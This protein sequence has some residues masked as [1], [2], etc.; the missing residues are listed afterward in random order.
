MLLTLS[1]PA[2]LEF[3]FKSPHEFSPPFSSSPK[4]F[5]PRLNG[6]SVLSLPAS[7]SIKMSTPHRG[8]P[9]PAAMTLPDPGGRGPPPIPT[10]L[11]QLPA[12][13]T[14]WQGAEDG[15]RNWLAAKA[16]E[17][18]RKQE[19]EK[20]RQE[21]LKMKQEDL[22][23]QQ[24]SYRL[25]QR[26]I[27]QAMLRESMQG[28]VPPHLVPMIFAGIG[29]ANL[30]NVSLEW[31][32]QYAAQLQAAQQQQQQQQQQ[33]ALNQAQSPEMRRESRIANVLQSSAFGGPQTSPQSVPGTSLI[34]TQQ[35]AAPLPQPGPFASS[36]YSLSPANRTRASSLVGQQLSGTKSTHSTLPRLTTNEMQIHQPPTIPP[37]VHP[38]HQTHTAAQEPNPPSPDIYF[39]H[40]V[41]PSSEKEKAKDHPPATPS[42]KAPVQRSSPHASSHLFES[43]H[44]SS[45][46]KRKAQGAHQPAPLP[47][48]TPQYTSPSFSQLASSASTPG[49]RGHTRTRS[50]TSTR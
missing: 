26:R 24:E 29:G 15:M 42:G 38:L 16:E 12:P 31:L 13:P 23:T 10:G 47:T 44:A 43:E 25:E 48:S 39:H 37:A 40:W 4:I 41:P 17:E 9:P 30:A 3:D 6:G 33:Q 2:K 27:E 7:T 21:D 20:T 50:D 36:A 19:E 8:L 46:K 14:Q 11:S 32:Q 28:G 45:P 22:R 18:K 35:M 49:R 5:P 1:N 34:P